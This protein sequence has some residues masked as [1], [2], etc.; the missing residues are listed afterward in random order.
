MRLKFKLQPYQT[1][2]V[3]AV[4]GAQP[5]DDSALFDHT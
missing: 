5:F 2:A 4:A 1:V 3:E